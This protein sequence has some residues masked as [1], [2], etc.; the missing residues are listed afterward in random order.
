VLKVHLREMGFHVTLNHVLFPLVRDEVL[1]SCRLPYSGRD[2]TEQRIERVRGLIRGINAEEHELNRLEAWHLE[3][4]GG[5]LVNWGEYRAGM[6]ILERAL[7]M[8][9][10]QGA[11]E[12][13]LHCLEHVGH[14]F[15]QTDNAPKLLQ[16]GRE[17][18]H[19]AKAAG[20]DHH[21]GLALRFIGMSKRIERDFARAEKIFLRSA[22]V[23]TDLSLSGRDY[24]LNI[25]APMCYLGE[26]R[27]WSGDADA[28]M[29]LFERC[30]GR[31]R[32]SGLFWG[33]SHFHAH[34]A[35]VALDVGDWDL[36]YSHVNEG[37]TLFESSSGGHCG[38]LLYSLKA[39]CDARRGLTNDA[40]E[41]IK[42]SEFLSAIGKR[43]WLA[44]HLMAKAW[45]A[46]MME[47]GEIDP[48]ALTGHIASPSRVLA[49]EAENLYRR[50]GA[51]G[52]ADF[53]R[54]RF[55][56]GA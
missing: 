40:A 43:T 2:E 32:D 27:Q 33:R 38:S 20:A 50:I 19:T 6:R 16:T 21:V 53:I 39:I 44:P 28:A 55:L 7:G 31:C 23:F 42:K 15:L 8:A 54:E 30:I 35:D 52:R 46:R 34:A 11:T 1:L 26:M 10:G 56:A 9:R 24:T 41:S 25:L 36:L 3:I 37:S 14:Y 13:R 49:G 48:T 4:W 5:Y 18:L 12:I 22:E 45:L 29:D 51:D 17:I 47:S